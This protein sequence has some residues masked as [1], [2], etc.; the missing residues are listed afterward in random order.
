MKISISDYLLS[1]LK[2]YG[3]TELF[4]VPG[5]YT[6]SFL[7]VVEASEDVKWIGCC[8][9][10]DAAYAADGYARIKGMGAI[11]VTYG[12]GELSA[13]NGIAGA[14]AERV[15]VVAIS[16]APAAQA[17]KDKLAMHH[18]LGHGV[19][20]NFRQMYAAV[21]CAQTALNY[22]DAQRQID[23][24]LLTCYKEKRPVYIEM[25]S[26]IAK[27]EIEIDHH[28]IPDMAYGESNDE[29][30][31]QF[32]LDVQKLLDTSKAQMVIADFEVERFGFKHKISHFLDKVKLPAMTMNMGKGVIDETSEYFVGIYLGKIS[33]QAVVDVAMHSDLALVFGGLFA[34]TTTEFTH[35]NNAMRFVEVHPYYCRIGETIYSNIFMGD[36]IEALSDLQYHTDSVVASYT[37]DTFEPTDADITQKR[38]YEALASTLPE[39][40][41]FIGET[42]TAFY[43]SVPMRLHGECRYIGQALWASI[44]YAMGA[45]LGSSI[46]DTDNRSYLL[47][48]DG[49]FQLTAQ[50]ISTIMRN[51]L[52]TVVMLINN[53]G[54]T[55][56]KAIHGRTKHYNDI[57][58]WKYS[59]LP[60]VLNMD[61]NASLCFK[62]KSERELINALNQAAATTDKMIFIEMLLAEF[63]MPWV[64]EHLADSMKSSDKF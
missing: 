3:I 10:L 1:Q 54:Y 57:N 8:N 2:R 63:D 37:P 58:M 35:V 24:I 20:N 45:A 4:G 62:V 17:V 52:N 9:E 26:D 55:I 44:G 42:G 48:G 29:S 32:I 33:E 36:V 51:N 30:L 50:T 19:F 43:G 60:K 61:D 21:T 18:S 16:G 53:N 15:P 28:A 23:Q 13:I 34:D 46:A 14:Y 41:I 22:C 27:L 59:E 39:G 56:E 64:L 38:L 31:Q 25:P 6:L 7:D 49:S 11:S 47:I 12:V 5:D 40:S